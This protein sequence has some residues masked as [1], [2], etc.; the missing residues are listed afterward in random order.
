M[1]TAKQRYYEYGE[2]LGI[3]INDLQRLESIRKESEWINVKDRLPKKRGWY[4]CYADDRN[5]NRRCKV[6]FLVSKKDGFAVD[7]YCSKPTHWMELP[8]SPKY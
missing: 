5:Y 6:Y 7:Q 2:S 8:E 3:K 4:L 1:K